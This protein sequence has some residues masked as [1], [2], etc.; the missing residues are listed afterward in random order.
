MAEISCATDVPD[1]T[2]RLREKIFG[3]EEAPTGLAETFRRLLL[4]ETVDIDALL[5]YSRRQ[6]R[7]IAVGGDKAK[8]IEPTAVKQI[9]G[10]DHQGDMTRFGHAASRYSIA[11]S[12]RARIDGGIAIP[13]A[14]AV[15]RLITGSNF[16][17][18]RTG[19][20]AG[21]APLRTRPA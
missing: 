11:P 18:G 19:K 10:I 12:A 4:A 3:E 15:S 8:S 13:S 7:E 2:P 21:W 20:P 1:P 9:H 17:A 5:A 14:F 6:P 16:D